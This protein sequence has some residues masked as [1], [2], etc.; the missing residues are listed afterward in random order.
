[1]KNS[2]PCSIEFEAS[3]LATLRNHSDRAFWILHDS[4]LQ[5]SRLEVTQ[6]DGS[7]APSFDTRATKKFDNTVR[8]SAFRRLDPGGELPLF[9]LSVSETDSAYELRWGPYRIGPLPRGKYSAAV[10]WE[11]HETHYFDEESQKKRALDGA[12]VGTV[13]SATVAFDLPLRF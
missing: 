11:A 5:P 9:Q 12:F 1:M 2:T 4:Y 3:K 13:R 7:L 6:A 10:V 8:K